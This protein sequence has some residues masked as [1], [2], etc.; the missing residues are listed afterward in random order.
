MADPIV[1]D[2]L[3]SVSA[4]CSALKKRAGLAQESFDHLLACLDQDRNRAGEVYEDLRRKLLR[5]FERRNC[6]F[7]DSYADE[8][9]DR[10]IRRIHEGA[11]IPNIENYCY[12]VAQLLLRE[13]VRERTKRQEALWRLE[14]I[15]KHSETSEEMESLLTWLEKAMQSLSAEDRG[16]IIAYY[17]ANKEEKIE[18][19]KRL[20][21]QLGMSVNALRI[22]AYRIRAELQKSFD[23]NLKIG[24][25]G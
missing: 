15:H 3:K 23:D 17:Q 20:A 11:V 21:E 2:R 24:Q 7:P 22:R 18:R 12:G 4:E 16:L 13:A 8:T 6:D 19:R 1:V 5:F 14:S 9:L 10:V 25:A